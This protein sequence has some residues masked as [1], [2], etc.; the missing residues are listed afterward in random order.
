MKKIYNAPTTKTVVI[1]VNKN[2]LTTT[3][4]AVG[5]QS[6]NGSAALGREDNSWDI[7]G[8]NDLDEE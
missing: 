1:N 3:S 5:T 2:V 4:I 7:W 8:N 6:V